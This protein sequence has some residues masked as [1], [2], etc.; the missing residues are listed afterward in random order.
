MK[1][2]TLAKFALIASVILGGTAA[3]AEHNQA[4]GTLKLK[5]KLALLSKLGTDS[6]HVDVEA[7][8]GAVSLTGTVDRRET[9]ELAETIAEAVSGVITVNN[10][11]HLEANVNNPSQAA[12]AAGETEAELKDAVLATKVRLALIDKMGTDGFRISTEVA[13][14][15]VTLEFERDFA[16]A[17]RQE[18]S[19]VTKA[20][21]GVTK[22]ITVE[23]A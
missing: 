2:K 8:N 20:V 9:R 13:S 18:A 14:G 4:D 1:L 3:Y 16:A 15:V 19:K 22:V 17:R 6:L 7:K 23:K 11:L 10:D 21:E 12:V 5:V